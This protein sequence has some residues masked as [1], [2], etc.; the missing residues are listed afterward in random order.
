[1]S[2]FRSGFGRRF[3]VPDKNNKKKVEKMQGWV[4]NG[5]VENVFERKGHLGIA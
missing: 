2:P 1:M 5:N 4:E 3:V